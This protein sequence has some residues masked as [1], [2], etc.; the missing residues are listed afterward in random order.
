MR[1]RSQRDT[2]SWF[3]RPSDFLRDSLTW[4]RD[5]CQRV[6]RQNDEFQAAGR[7]FAISDGTGNGLASVTFAESA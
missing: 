5:I 1:S 3:T 6:A 7:Q 4:L 2:F